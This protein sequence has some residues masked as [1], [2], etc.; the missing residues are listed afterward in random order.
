MSFI[1]ELEELEEL[2]KLYIICKL[3]LNRCG[4][5]KRGI[6]CKNKIKCTIDNSFNEIHNSCYYFK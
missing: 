6:L 4:I 2:D 1:N 5:C 3:N